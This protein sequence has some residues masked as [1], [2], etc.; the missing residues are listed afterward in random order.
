M[1][2]HMPW[3]NGILSCRIV[4]C[5]MLIQLFARESTLIMS[6]A[7]CDSVGLPLSWCLFTCCSKTLHGIRASKVQHAHSK[8]ECATKGVNSFV[9]AKV[10]QYQFPIVH[11]YECSCWFCFSRKCHNV[12][13]VHR[14]LLLCF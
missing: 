12:R 3:F 2:Q 1:D 5:M 14:L 10:I 9:G 13:R 8:S 6:H 11:Y 4:I 7:S